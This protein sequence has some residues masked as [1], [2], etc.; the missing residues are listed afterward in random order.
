MHKREGSLG[1]KI[2]EGCKELHKCHIKPEVCY[3]AASLLKTFIVQYNVVLI[4]VWCSSS[5]ALCSTVQVVFQNRNKAH[6]QLTFNLI[7]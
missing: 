6:L 5:D 2:M 1:S 7:Y 3:K 4:D